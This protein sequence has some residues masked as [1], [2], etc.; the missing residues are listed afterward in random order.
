MGVKRKT[1]KLRGGDIID[2]EEY[3][4][5]QYG[6]P[7]QKRQKRQKP[8][9]E[10]VRQV[11]AR[12]KAKRCRQRLLQ[13]FHPGDCFCTWTYNPRGR[14]E[15]MKQ[16]LKDFGD[17]MKIVRREYRKRGQKLYWIRN[18]EKGTKGAWHIH[19]VI[20]EI[21]ETASILQKAW[22]H[23]GLYAVEIRNNEK[24]AD[25]DF[26]RLASYMTKDEYTTEKKQDGTD[27]KPR[28]R[29]AS[30]ST[31]R[32]MPLP[33]PRQDKL[34]RWQKEPKPKKGYYIAD[35]YEGINPVTGY[36]YRRYTMIRLNRR[37]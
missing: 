29:E 7:G 8:T 30:Y 3:H 24:F 34:V 10:Q 1:Y 19:L 18:I 20:N 33:E 27:G 6:A 22:K 23:G 4:D 2:V 16:A 13:Y 17:A 28:I 31:S 25:E 12:N 11:N 5:G 9:K 32:N 21:G 26:T 37:E 35:C 14:P 15:D 36:Q